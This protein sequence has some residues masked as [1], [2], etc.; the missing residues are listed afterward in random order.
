VLNIPTATLILT[1]A[2]G[3]VTAYIAWQQ[4]RTAKNKFRLDLFDRRFPM[5]VATM[6][7]VELAVTKGEIP[8]EEVQKFAFATKGMEF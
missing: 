5:F 4:W 1:G 8:F 7:L 3:C 2:I 6:R